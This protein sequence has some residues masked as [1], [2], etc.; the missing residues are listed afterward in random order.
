M[1]ILPPPRNYRMLT[2]SDCGPAALSAATGLPREEVDDAWGW[3]RGDR[4]DSPWHHDAAMAR[5]GVTRRVVTCGE[6]CSGG[7]V[8]GRTVV[9]IH[10]KGSPILGQHWIV[11]AGLDAAGRV[12]LHMGDGRTLWFDQAVFAARYSGGAPACAYEV[13]RGDVPRVPWYQRLYMWVT[14]R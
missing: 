6:I 3:W 2:D 11:F 4:T 7:A 14:R 8:P 1:R 10:S 12:G 13:G 5:L 9:L